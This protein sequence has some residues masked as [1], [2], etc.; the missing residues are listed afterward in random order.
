MGSN[1]NYKPLFIDKVMEFS[2]SFPDY[3]LG[4]MLHSIVTQLQKN[5]VDVSSKGALLNLTDQQ[6]YSAIDNAIKEENE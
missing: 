3:S 6:L 4:E 1:I 5:G 2:E